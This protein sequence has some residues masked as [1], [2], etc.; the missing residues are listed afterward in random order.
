MSLEQTSSITLQNTKLSLSDAGKGE[1]IL[2]L[3][4]NPG[5]KNTFS[6]LMKKLDGLNI[7]LMA[8][9]RPGHNSS[10]ELLGDKNDLW[11][12]TL[13]YS[14]LI[15][16]KLGGKAWLL[17]HSYGCLTA[18]KIAIKHP[19]NV[20][21]IIMINPQI[22]PDNPKAGCS[23]IPNLAKGAFLGTIFG[24]WL[25][26]EYNEIFTER[27][28]KL[29]SPTVPNDD[30]KERWVQRFSRFESV[31]AFLTDN[32]TQIKIQSEL[33]QEVSNLKTPVYALFGEKDALSNLK[34]Q[35]DFVAT[36]PGAKSETA[37]EAGHYM[38]VLNPDACIDFIKKSI[39]N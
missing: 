6:E 25:P 10:E 32:N 21:G 4:G 5:S 1:P 26:N 16:N 15:Q 17:G 23:I 18:L 29:Y 27:I 22:V 24:V 12:D 31:I 33:T 8:L 38:P 13:V 37:A 9:D 36:I 7:K 19:E 3:H 30:E 20:K 11:N 2:C 34:A 39:N 35:Q 14:E 28:E